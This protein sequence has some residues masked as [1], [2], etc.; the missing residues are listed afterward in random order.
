MVRK[1]TAFVLRSGAGSPPAILVLGGATT[2]D[3]PP[4]LPG[5]TIEP[6]ETPEEA[7][8][9]ELAE[10][11]GLP[12]LTVVRKLGVQCYFKV[13][14]GAEVERH[15]FLLAAPARTPSTWRHRVTGTGK[16]AGDELCCWF[17]QPLEVNQVDEEHRSALVP[18]YLPELFA[19]SPR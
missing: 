16:D 6:L 12:A 18:T 4:R 2:R 13:Y 8:H 14:I 3:L 11:T 9:R 10:E 5:G 19:A 1:V 7:L 17:L 15:D